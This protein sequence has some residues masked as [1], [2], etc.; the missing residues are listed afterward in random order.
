V[1]PPAADA[2]ETELRCDIGALSFLGMLVI[3]RGV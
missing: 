3:R 2:V 1:P